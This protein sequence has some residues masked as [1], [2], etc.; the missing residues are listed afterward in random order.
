MESLEQIPAMKE[1]LKIAPLA[2]VRAFHKSIFE[3]NGDRGNWQRLRAFSGF[4]FSHECEDLT[5]KKAFAGKNLTQG[6]L[7]AIC[8]LLGLNYSGTK[9]KLIDRIYKGLMD[10]DFHHRNVEDEENDEDEEEVDDEGGNENKEDEIDDY[11]TNDGA[12]P[13][14]CTNQW[15]ISCWTMIS[16]IRRPIKTVRLE[17]TPEI[18]ICKEIA[19][20]NCKLFIQCEGTINT[21]K[22]LKAVLIKEFS[23]K[24]NSAQLHELLSKRKKKKD[25]T[26]QEYFLVMK[27]WASRGH[28]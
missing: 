18:N 22:T 28:I 16:R 10:L 26:V 8:N 20:W 27:K 2:P 12:I 21:W 9:E 14:Q 3:E 23:K 13:N 25:A 6:D 1:A 15:Q 5:A 11:S 17:W 19:H 24:I 4:T 7:I